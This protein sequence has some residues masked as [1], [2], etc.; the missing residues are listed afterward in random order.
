MRLSVRGRLS[1]RR[2]AALVLVAALGPVVAAS[3]AWAC[4][5][6]VSLT[7]SAATV[8]PGATVTVYG[9]EFAQGAPVLIHLDT[10][11]GAV[12][13]TVPPPTTTM[14]SQFTAQVTIPAGTSPGSHLLVA[15]Q[16]EHNMN[17][18][19]PARAQIFVGTAPLAPAAPAS[20]PPS[21]ITTSGPGAGSLALIAM[22][23]AAAGL[24]VVGASLA[25][26]GRRREGARPATGPARG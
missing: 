23:V 7:T 6:I 11:S 1:V 14:T 24:T 4:V 26:A 19:I 2:G 22:G 16:D 20:R 3:G 9:K 15:T 5:G 12:L 10:P 18:G 25:V 17:G 21:V 13:A 8:A